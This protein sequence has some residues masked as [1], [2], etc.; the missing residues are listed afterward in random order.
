MHYRSKCL[1]CL[2]VFTLPTGCGSP[3]P[4]AP[5]P[6]A[7]V[8]VSEPKAREVVDY[9][10]FTGRTDAAS[11]I[12]IRA[13]VSGYLI[14][15]D[16]KDGDI[17]K[18][19]DLLYEID[20]RPFQAA[21]DEAKGQ[22]QYLLAAK[23]LADI[24]VGR[25]TELAKKSAASQQD[26]DQYLA[27]QAENLGQLK[28][29]EAA[30]VNAQLN[31]DFTRVT[32]PIAGRVSR[33]FITAGNLVNADTTLL[34]T[35]RS[36][37]PMYAYFNIEEPT[38]LRIQKMVRDGIIKT[39]ATRTVHVQMGLADDVERKFPLSG[40]LDFINNTVD[41]QTGTLQVRGTFEN[42]YTAGGPPPILT[43]GLFVR[44]RLHVGVPH[45]V[46]LV[47]ERAIGTDQGLKFVYVV[48]KDDKVLYRPVKLGLMFDGLQAIEE[49][50]KPGERVVVNGLQRIRPGVQVQTDPTDMASLASPGQPDRKPIAKPSG[51]KPSGVQPAAPG[52]SKK[53]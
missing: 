35:L 51:T 44:V 15:V 38:V 1:I 41:P 30:V 25:Y 26:L 46:L 32:A 11:S 36:I 5:P 45:Q 27:Q 7:Q 48:D 31:L 34:T 12:D 18:Q 47:T 14:K 10:D 39:R 28:T 9:E 23:K 22:V 2:F 3:P 16:F 17:V 20:P 29:A 21:L 43:P 52:P 13:R 49:G 4:I 33:T 8:T 24:Q 53:S 50:L 6:V 19:G 40:L 37:N 42:P